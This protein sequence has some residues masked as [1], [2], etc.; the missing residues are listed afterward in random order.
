MVGA[1]RTAAGRRRWSREARTQAGPQLETHLQVMET[2][3]PSRATVGG[4]GERGWKQH[5]RLTLWLG[6][7][8]SGTLGGSGNPF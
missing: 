3:Q 8:L 4:G 7:G 2:V 1:V 5:H 6:H